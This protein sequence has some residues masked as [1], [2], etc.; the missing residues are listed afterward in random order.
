MLA[1]C[2]LMLDIHMLVS[3]FLALPLVA[4]HCCCCL[5]ATAGTSLLNC[6]KLLMDCYM[7]LTD[8][9]TLLLEHC[10][11]LLNHCKLLMD[12]CMLLTDHCT[13]LLGQPRTGGGGCLLSGKLVLVTFNPSSASKWYTLKRER[14]NKDSAHDFHSL[15]SLWR[16]TQP[17]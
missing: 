5:T 17:S 3:E 11:P 2:K 13:L 12:F 7:L 9:C 10:R 4:I 16:T 8:H 6:C 14:I 1:L 15:A